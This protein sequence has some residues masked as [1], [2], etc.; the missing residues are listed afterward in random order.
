MRKIFI[1][2]IFIVSFNLYSF[3]IAIDKIFSKIEIEK[4]I[5]GEIITRRYMKYNPHKLN[6]HDKIDIPV[7]EFTKE[8]YTIYE[9]L[10][11][12]KA[13]IPYEIKNEQDLLKIF[14]II[15]SVSLAKGMKYY[16][17]RAGAVLEFIVDSYMV[18]SSNFFKKIEDP[19]YDKVINKTE[20]FFYQKDNRFGKLL[21]KKIVY[22]EDNNFYI[23][24]ECLDPIVFVLPLNKKGEYKVISYFIYDKERKGY[25][26]Y[27]LLA[28]R[29]RNDFI[30]KKEYTNATLF[31]SRLRAVTIHFAKLI[32]LDWYNKLKE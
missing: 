2:I 28:T 29:V 18:D 6:T 24:T 32:G 8:D 16:S 20:S 17:N 15:N 25:F 9:V 27:A 23:I 12:E 4:V 21:Y 11:D 26:Y 30:L 10:I 7:T 13:F 22:N 3:D 14:N 1:F 5:K 31:S 19:V